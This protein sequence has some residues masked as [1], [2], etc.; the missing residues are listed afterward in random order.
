MTHSIAKVCYPFEKV[1]LIEA[2]SE[3]RSSSCP[4]CTSWSLP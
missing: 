4:S 2:A 1:M 3:W